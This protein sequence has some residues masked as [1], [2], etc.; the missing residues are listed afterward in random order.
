MVTLVVASLAGGCKPA[1]PNER[2]DTREPTASLPAATNVILITL[3]T[4]RADRLGCYGY[5]AASTPGMDALA[6]RGVHFAQAIAQAPLTLPSHA[7]MMTGRYPRELGVRVNGRDSL[8]DTPVTL[9]T[10]AKQQ[11]CA[12]G[13]F[14]G[15]SVLDA[16]YG[17]DRGF[18]VYGDD[19]GR[20]K[21]L[22]AHSDP[23]R[24]GAAV[25]DEALAWLDTVKDQKFLAWIHYY[26]P[27]HPY[28]APA[29]FQDPS[30]APYDREIAYMDA[31]IARVVEWLDA[32][33]LTDR[34]LL[35][36]VGD[37]GEGFGEHGERGHTV[38]VYETNVHV[39]MIFVH[40]SLPAGRRVEPV[41]EVVDVF[42]TIHALLGWTPPEGLLS[43]SLAGAIRGSDIDSTQSYSEAHHVSWSFGW[44]EQRALTTER[45]KYISSTRPELFD[46]LND[47]GELTTV[48]ARYPDVAKQMREALLARFNAMKP[49]QAKAVVL[50]DK[51]RREL[52]SLGY[53]SG[54]A[55]PESQEFLT[56]GRPDPKDMLDAYHV[57]KRGFDLLEGGF[58]EEAIPHLREAV[59]A[60]PM[61]MGFH[62]ML[63][64]AYQESGH[65]AEAV[66][67]LQAALRID[68]TYRSA[69]SLLAASLVALGRQDEAIAHYE[70]AIKL[71]P[72]NAYLKASLGQVLRRAE[73]PDDALVYLRQAI[74]TEPDHVLALNELGII[75]QTA[76]DLRGAVGFYR[77]AVA[78]K[79]D[80]IEGLY[81]LSTVLLRLGEATE[82]APLL[83]RA[84]EL[85]PS[86]GDSVMT[87]GGAYAQKG[88]TAEAQACFEAVA[89]VEGVGVGARFNL[90]VMAARRG[91]REASVTAYERV[92]DMAPAHEKT[93]AALV[94]LYLS[95]KQT[96]KAVRMLRAAVGS[97]PDSLTVLRPLS[98]LLAT[99]PQDD[100]RDGALAV[101]LAERAARLTQRKDPAVLATLG[102][103]LAETGQFE[104]A[105]QV[106]TEAIE[107]ARATNT[108]RLAD[109]IEMQR[110]AY[111]AGRPFR[112]ASL[113]P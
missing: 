62:Y 97:A 82:G 1:P 66:A 80:G 37:H 21:G 113:Q 5:A 16:K 68:P 31:Q 99:A 8:G 75:A 65:H 48:I 19:M 35:V 74:D 73:R 103:G 64:A 93:V 25:T 105:V 87:E 14:V 12:T 84:V 88:K 70:I 57:M 30:V 50:D 111:R 107:L 45:W 55:T 71:D 22:H 83:R 79:P 77:R 13:G 72:T 6:A 67:A 2:A 47:P 58:A 4:T 24:R 49:G 27:H 17:L 44:A 69:L 34:T 109:F 90:A 11:G 18:D 61:S 96:G 85:K 86:L 42:L 43:R 108:G 32:R 110:E 10:Q 92:L 102:A 63:G 26:D 94:N 81:N 46:R 39:P 41:V 104:T 29:P 106:A 38:F 28:D 36:L 95:A 101:T 7:T 60:S 15:A 78:A 76:G 91:D 33:R 3:D 56:P 52:E 59:D 89:D 112:D 51:S 20:S 100:L 53:L 54:G 98:S 9:A 40:P 23:Q